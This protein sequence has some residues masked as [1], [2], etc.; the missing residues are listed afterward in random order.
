MVLSNDKSW[1][2][3]RV[4]AFPSSL[5]MA[6]LF[7]LVFALA[8]SGC[9]STTD[10][11]VTEE[12]L[13]EPL[14][15]SV[16]SLLEAQQAGS[17]DVP[18]RNGGRGSAPMPQWDDET[19]LREQRA[20][21]PRVFE[22]RRT[23]P[24]SELAPPPV[25]ANETPAE[26]PTPVRPPVVRQ[27]TQQELIVQ[28][29]NRLLTDARPALERAMQ[30]AVLASFNPDRSLEPR[31][32][33]ILSSGERKLVEQY[34][35]LLVELNTQL[36]GDPFETDSAKLREKVDLL[37]A[38]RPLSIR[39]VELCREVQGYGLYEPVD[40]SQWVAGR[41]HRAIVYVEIDNF[42]SQQVGE[43]FNVELVQTI[44]LFNAVDGLLVWQQAPVQVQDIS[45]NRRR[46]FFTVQLIE[47]P[48]TLNVGKYIL[49]VRV[50]D[51]Q[52]NT[53][54]EVKVPIQ[55]V[56]DQSAVRRSGQ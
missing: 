38:E 47:L 1:Q 39:T 24:E 49:N 26:E 21:R 3:M 45:R 5:M 30:A 48:A 22:D 9:A 56:A 37:L 34:Y 46:D 41:L 42:V 23:T 25:E 14:P 4:I 29:Q 43:K 54:D 16:Q 31:V 51:E 50:K 36:T 10:T 13:D 19:A 2:S 32:L 44:E 15:D 6:G 12:T 11:P 17:A 55:I 53:L 8:L 35:A 18:F 33:S 27:L 40:V 28:L 7:V 20:T 52:A